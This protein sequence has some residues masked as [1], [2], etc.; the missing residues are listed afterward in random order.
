[1]EK[2]YQGLLRYV[3]AKLRD[4]QRAADNVHDAMR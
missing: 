1:M 2:Y 4:R 3:S